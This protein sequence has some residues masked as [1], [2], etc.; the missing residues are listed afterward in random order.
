[1]L[2]I[3]IATLGS[4]SIPLLNFLNRRVFAFIKKIKLVHRRPTAWFLSKRSVLLRSQNRMNWIK[5][6]FSIMFQV[7]ATYAVINIIILQI[8]FLF[9]TIHRH[10]PQ[11]KQSDYIL[12]NRPATSL[13][14]YLYLSLILKIFSTAS[15]A[16]ISIQCR[17]S[18]QLKIPTGLNLKILKPKL[19][20]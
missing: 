15:A 20:R 17:S 18:L 3:L 19:L 11:L 6:G 1:M 14:L 9:Q 16:L 4:D 2:L 12:R 13:N 10:L 7:S 8:S 5:K